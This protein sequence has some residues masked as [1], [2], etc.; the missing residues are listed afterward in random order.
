MMMMM[1]VVGA[2]A[3]KSGLASITRHGSDCDWRRR[4]AI[5]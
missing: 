1:M 2:F 5:N 4:D 3:D